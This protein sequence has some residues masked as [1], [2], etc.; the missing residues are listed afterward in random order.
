LQYRY[1]PAALAQSEILRRANLYRARWYVQPDD[2]STPIA[3][4]DTFEGQVQV[5]AGS[6][7]WGI[8][9][10]EFDG[11]SFTQVAGANGVIQVTDACTGIALFGEYVSGNA[12]T[13]FRTSTDFRADIVPHIL[14]QPRLI[15]AP[16]LLNIEISNRSTAPLRCQLILFFAEPCVVIGEKQE[17]VRGR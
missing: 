14:S 13:F 2:A 9:Y 5:M 17:G 4:Y 12:F 15:L 6:Y 10:T 11:V 1:G 8:Q 7:L 3:A 16:G